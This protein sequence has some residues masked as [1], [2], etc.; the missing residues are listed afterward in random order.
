MVQARCLLTNVYYQKVLHC[1]R[2]TLHLKRFLKQLG[3]G[4]LT[5]SNTEKGG[6]LTDSVPMSTR[7]SQVTLSCG[8]GYLAAN[9]L[10]LG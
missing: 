6:Q 3:P 7:G 2:V 10:T 5:K 4:V 1:K 8:L 9:S